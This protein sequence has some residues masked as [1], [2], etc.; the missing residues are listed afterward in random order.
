M[1]EDIG[2]IVDYIK[3]KK[4]MV[5]LISNGVL[6]RKKIRDLKNLDFLVL[7]YDG[8]PVAQ[9]DVRGEKA[10]AI[11]L[12]AIDAAKEHKIKLFT[13]TVLTKDNLGEVDSILQLADQKGFGCEIHPVYSY[14][15]SKGSSQHLMPSKKDFDKTVQRLKTL[16]KTKL[17]QHI[18]Y[19]DA[20]LDYLS[21][22]PKF[23][24]QKCWAGNAYVYIDTDGRMYPCNQMINRTKGV[25][26]LEVGIEEAMKRLERLPCK[27]CWCLSN[28]E[29]NYLCSF[30]PK[31]LWNTYKL[32]KDI[33]K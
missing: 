26:V 27:G 2:E 5:N 1:R 6:V 18:V 10:H 7:S 8:S 12:D 9:K 25:P 31:A 17:G 23:K 24:K 21:T 28:I 13:A 22:W 29:Y 30:N 4:I 33:E 20:T 16:K 19:S 3:S 11:V 15:L 32:A 14:S